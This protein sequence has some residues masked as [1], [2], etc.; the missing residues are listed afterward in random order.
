MKFINHPAVQFFVTPYQVRCSV[1]GTFICYLIVGIIFL[2]FSIV[3]YLR[4]SSIDSVSVRFDDECELNEV[5]VMD[6]EIP[7]EMEAPILVFY[8]IDKLYQNHRNY[9][10]SKHNEQEVRGIL[11]FF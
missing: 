3:L 9:I 8:E 7:E 4:G 6:F 11:M 5:C 1:L 2:T 10:E